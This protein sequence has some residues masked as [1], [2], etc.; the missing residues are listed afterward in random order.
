MQLTDLGW[1]SF[2][3]KH[4]E[5]YRNKDY[6][7]MRITRVDKGKYIARNGTGEYTCKITGKFRFKTDRKSKF[8]TVGDWV[9][10]SILPGEKKAMIHSLLP[11]MSVFSRKVS[12]KVTEEQIV[13]ANIDT[14]FIV[15]GLDLNF[16]LRRIERYLAISKESGA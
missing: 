16:N 10:T 8:P 12:G 1:N 9:I 11:R 7:A 3:D 15:T 4:Y 6:S 13:A 14:V 2:F 5:Q